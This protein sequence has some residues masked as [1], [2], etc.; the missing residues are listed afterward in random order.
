MGTWAA[1]NF[2]SDRALDYVGEIIDQLT[3]T[4]ASCL[5]EGDADLDE[6]GES[7]LM[8]SVAIIKVLSE[9]CGA[10]PPKSDVI[11]SWRRQYLAIYDEQI[12]DLEPD[13]EYKVERRATIDTTF[14]QLV[15]L[16][17]EFWRTEPER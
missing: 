15:A 3:S 14:T 13:P 8:P 10:A 17:K 12:D 11:E 4:V 7:E 16:A 9:H 5:E 2:D 1:G 6:G